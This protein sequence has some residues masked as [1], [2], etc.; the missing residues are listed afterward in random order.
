MLLNR[1]LHLQVI[2]RGAA[3]RRKPGGKTSDWFVRDKLLY[4][5][6]FVRRKISAVG[7]VWWVGVSRLST[8]YI[9]TRQTRR[10]RFICDS[11]SVVGAWYGSAS[12]S[13][14]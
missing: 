10:S 9:S 6:S 13:W 11:E 12:S 1:E 14:L 7:G 3:R 5:H 8:E 4:I 2:R